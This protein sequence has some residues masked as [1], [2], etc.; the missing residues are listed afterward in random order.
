MTYSV[1][2]ALWRGRFEVIGPTLSP[3]TQATVGGDE[4]MLQ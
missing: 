1:T 3:Y 4:E 2:R